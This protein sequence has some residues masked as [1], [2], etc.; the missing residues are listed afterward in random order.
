MSIVVEHLKQTGTIDSISEQH[1]PEPLQNSSTSGTTTPSP[2]LSARGINTPPSPKQEPRKA[3]VASPPQ[4]PV[5][6]T[7][8]SSPKEKPSVRFSNARGPADKDAARTSRPAA[9]RTYSNLELSTIDQKWGMLF[10]HD[11]N[12]TPRLGQ[13]LRGLANHIVSTI[14]LTLETMG[15]V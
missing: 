10:D 12:P 13:F 2:P 9:Y 6:D 4:S 11:R 8:Q 14:I 15:S 7:Q 5:R 1:K 3:T